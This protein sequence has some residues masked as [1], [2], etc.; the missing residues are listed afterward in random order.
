MQW[1][2]C[3]QFIDESEDPHGIVRELVDALPPGSYI[4]ISHILD[5]RRTREIADIQRRANTRAWTP[6]SK[7]QILRFFDGLELVDPGLSV[8]CRWRPDPDAPMLPLPESLPILHN[9][10][11]SEQ[12]IEWLLAGIGRKA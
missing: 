5:D 1:K 3:V 11:G 7:A 9:P 12:D 8:A 6:R 2:A 4:T 10:D